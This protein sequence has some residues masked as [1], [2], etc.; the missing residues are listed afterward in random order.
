MDFFQL[1]FGGFSPQEDPDAAVKFCLQALA[2]DHRLPAL[3]NLLAEG[4]ETGGIEG[5][6]GW[7]LERRDDG[8]A[9][10]GYATWPTG[11]KFRAF[12]DPQEY[13]LATPERFYT[14]AE[15]LR[16]VRAVVDAYAVRYPDRADSLMSVDLFLRRGA[17]VA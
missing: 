2:A 16:F 10:P 13:E 17:T 7:L 1:A 9:A 5:V 12:V 3:V 14:R 4:S 8:D 15:F 11:A 6:P